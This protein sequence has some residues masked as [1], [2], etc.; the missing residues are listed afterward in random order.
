MIQLVLNETA[1]ID[2]FLNGYFRNIHAIETSLFIGTID[3]ITCQ[4]KIK[5]E[6][7]NFFNDSSKL[8]GE[9]IEKRK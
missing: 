7:V 3:F 1:S 6:L 2:K 4:D 5:K 9:D 8:I